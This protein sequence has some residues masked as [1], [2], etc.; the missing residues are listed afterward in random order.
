MDYKEIKK[1]WTQ[2]WEEYAKK[3]NEM[4]EFWEKNWWENWEWEEAEETRWYISKDIF[5]LLK[6]ANLENNV[7]NFRKDFPA[8][9]S[10]FV[11]MLDEKWQFIGD[12]HFISGEKIIFLVWNHYEKRQAYILDGENIEKISDEIRNIW[13]SF[14]NEIF[15][16]SYEDKIILRKWWNWEILKEFKREDTKEKE[17]FENVASKII[18]FNDWTKVLFISWDWIFIISE[19]WEK[20][21]HPSFDEDKE[22]NFFEKDEDFFQKIDMENATLSNDNKY[23]VVWDQDR[24][25]RILNEN[26]QKIWEIWPQSSYSHFSLFS[27]NDEILITNSCHFYNWIT[28]WVSWKKLYWLEVEWWQEEETN[29]KFFDFDMRIY[30]WLSTEKYFIF[31]DAYG[32]IR[33]FDFEGN[34][35]WQHFLGSTISW[36]TISEDEKTLWVWSYSWILHKL[37]LW[38]WQDSHT[39]WNW[40]HKE[41]RRFLIWKWEKQILKW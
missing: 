41:E 28:I 9:T 37:K 40:N 2:E 15:A 22:N 20:L 16:I 5:D 30:E 33:A 29:F 11:E 19:N 3:I 31:W 12:L 38:E 17:N 7:E 18:P 13:K 36:M 24:D 4:V 35:I 25:F 26:F 14:K 1:I 39:I 6:K 8:I 10:P 32:Y 34:K 23:L 27:K 21:I